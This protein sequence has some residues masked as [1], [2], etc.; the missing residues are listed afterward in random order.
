ML[1]RVHLWPS[2]SPRKRCVA[3]VVWTIDAL[4]VFLCL[5][6]HTDVSLK[7]L[8]S[9]EIK[10][11]ITSQLQW[12]S[13]LMP[14]TPLQFGRCFLFCTNCL[15]GVCFSESQRF[16]RSRIFASSICSCCP[17]SQELSTPSSWWLTS[18]SSHWLS[19]LLKGILTGNE[20]INQAL[21]S[22]TFSHVAHQFGPAGHIT[23]QHL[24]HTVAASQSWKIFTGV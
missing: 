22:V 1:P 8:Q 6:T 16:I 13:V 17:R 20:T 9:S 2:R 18:S 21:P 23:T 14:F 4:F 15:K 5:Y 12:A 7:C 19:A 24:L 3:H 11:F 10:T